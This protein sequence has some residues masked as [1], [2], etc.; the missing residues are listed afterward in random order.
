MGRLM[1]E[2]PRRNPRGL[3]KQRSRELIM[4]SARRLFAELGYD[5]ATVRG[6][7]SAAGLTTGAVFASFADKA[8]LFCAVVAAERDAL[9]EVMRASEV[10]ERVEQRLVATFDAGLGFALREPSL[11]PAAISASW[12]PVLGR[13]VRHRS[14][15]QP[16]RDL[17]SDILNAGID[18]G[19]VASTTDVPLI[20]DLLWGCFLLNLRCGAFEGWQP[21]Q[22][23]VRLRRQTRIVLAS[24]TRQTP[25]TTETI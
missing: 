19:E 2:S 1:I 23:R 15:R 18:R 13:R 7:A 14:V 16:F 5:G 12:S 6:I 11:L 8:G 22:L 21:K 25:A 24:Q 3:A 17:V 9:L 10:G 4:A 20:A